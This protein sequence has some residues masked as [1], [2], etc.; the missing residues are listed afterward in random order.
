M[1]WDLRALGGATAAAGGAAAPLRVG[2]LQLPHSAAAAAEGERSSIWAGGPGALAAGSSSPTVGDA[3]PRSAAALPLLG[4][5][6]LST[7]PCSFGTMGRT[8]FDRFS[9]TYAVP[10]RAH[11]GVGIGS[12]SQSA[13]AAA[14]VSS[15]CGP[16]QLSSATILPDGTRLLSTD[17]AGTHRVWRLDVLLSMAAA[18]ANRGLSASF[19]APLEAGVCST[20]LPPGLGVNAGAGACDGRQAPPV[21][22]GFTAGNPRGAEHAFTGSPVGC[23]VQVYNI[24][25]GTHCCVLAQPNARDGVTVSA[26]ALSDDGR[27]LVSGDTAGGLYLRH[28]ANVLEGDDDE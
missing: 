8:V 17:M 14:P 6:H 13:A 1:L 23:A 5:M 16:G 15:H 22:L 19:D 4:E 24:A 26:L 18:R 3:L 12:N 9:G 27:A 11:C 10:F 21:V 28:T 25:D 20:L 2:A 7:A